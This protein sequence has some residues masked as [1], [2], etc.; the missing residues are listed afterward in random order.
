MKK[1]FFNKRYQNLKD[2]NTVYIVSFDLKN[3]TFRDSNGTFWSSAEEFFNSYKLVDHI[4]YYWA[5]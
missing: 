3:E 2:N 4:P 1:V 5:W